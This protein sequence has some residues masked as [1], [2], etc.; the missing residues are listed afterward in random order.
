MCRFSL[1][2]GAF[3]FHFTSSI[4]CGLLFYSVLTTTFIAWKMGFGLFG[5]IATSMAIGAFMGVK[6]Y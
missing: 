3:V 4:A 6:A 2:C 5:V 1:F